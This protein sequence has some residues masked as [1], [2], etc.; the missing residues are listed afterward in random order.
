M[1]GIKSCVHAL[2]YGEWKIAGNFDMRS[3][4]ASEFTIW[5]EGVANANDGAQ[6]ARAFARVRKQVKR[7]RR[8]TMRLTSACVFA[9]F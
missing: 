8:T 3:S 1:R 5:L 9:L 2:Q 6:I 4:D 7:A